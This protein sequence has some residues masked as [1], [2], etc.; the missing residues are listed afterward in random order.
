M[1]TIT[2]ILNGKTIPKN[3]TDLINIF[4][5]GL[6]YYDDDNE[7]DDVY[8]GYVKIDVFGGIMN[9]NINIGCNYR[10]EELGNYLEN[11]QDQPI[12]KVKNGIYIDIDNLTN[13][14]SPKKKRG[15]IYTS[16]LYKY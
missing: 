16:S 9:D 4:Y 12:W 7:Y 6:R 13:T 2:Q 8:E 14:Q 1:K 5:V 11:I 10:G 15:K 3:E